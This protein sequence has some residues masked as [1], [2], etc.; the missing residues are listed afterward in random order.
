[1]SRP[2]TVLFDMSNSDLP[3]LA[4]IRRIFADAEV[5]VI[6]RPVSKHQPHLKPFSNACGATAS[7]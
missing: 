5:W 1:M 7:N 3:F 6:F 4:P 2:A